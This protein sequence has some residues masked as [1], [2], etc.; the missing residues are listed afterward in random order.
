MREHV[1]LYKCIYEE[2]K[3]L[4]RPVLTQNVRD[5]QDYI[6]TTVSCSVLPLFVVLR[7]THYFISNTDSESSLV[8][9]TS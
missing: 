3:K 9:Q 5:F 4:E 7:F 2:R 1:Q 6:H 8:C